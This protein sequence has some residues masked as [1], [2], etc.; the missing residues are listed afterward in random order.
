MRETDKKIKFTRT[1]EF[2][3]AT[4]K[5]IMRS[6]ISGD[7]ARY[8]RYSLNNEKKINSTFFSKTIYFLDILLKMYWT[9]SDQVLLV[10]LVFI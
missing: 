2:K 4:F 10:Y 8:N 1:V 7:F 6:K 9:C 3:Q 5:L